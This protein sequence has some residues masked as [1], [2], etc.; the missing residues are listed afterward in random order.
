MDLGGRGE[1]TSCPSTFIE[2]LLR[3]SCRTLEL[4]VSSKSWLQ[5]SLEPFDYFAY[6]HTSSI[7]LCIQPAIVY[8]FRLMIHVVIAEKIQRGLS[9]LAVT[10]VY[11]FGWNWK[12]KMCM[13]VESCRLS[14]LAVS[15]YRL[16]VT[17]DIVQPRSRLLFID[18]RHIN[19][20]KYN[21][22]QASWQWRLFIYNIWLKS[23]Q[24]YAWN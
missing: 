19:R 12:Y 14:N 17:V 22:G 7:N 5:I 18:S 10:I 21:V 16:S 24:K 2:C 8:K 13:W 20:K 1:H 9:T 11:L 4:A 23:V 6:W 15:I 3:I